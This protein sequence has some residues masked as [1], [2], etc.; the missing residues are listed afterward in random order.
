MASQD[1]RFRVSD[2]RTVGPD[3]A[4]RRTG[5]ARAPAE[6]ANTSQVGRSEAIA[7]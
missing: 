3:H 6:L 4:I 7:V 5:A 1:R 2:H